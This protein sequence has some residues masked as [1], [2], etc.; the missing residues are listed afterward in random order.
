MSGADTKQIKRALAGGLDAAVADAATRFSARAEQDDLARVAYAS[1]ESPLGRGYVAAT[2][3][4][5]VGVA[6]PGRDLDEFLTQ[7]SAGVSPLVL[8]LPGRLDEARRELDEYFGGRRH[9]FGLR[10]D[11]GLSRPGFFTRVLRETAKVPYGATSTYADV[12]ARAGSPRAFRAAG[13]A[14]GHNP[15]PLVVPCHRVVRAGG[16]LGNYGGGPEMK[17]YL[18]EHEGA[19]T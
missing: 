8:E 3:R 19:I 12:A 17:R 4:G 5:V 14:L 2:R 18:L 11:W 13:T 7:L 15:L 6:L 1:Y 9:D 16:V 10:L